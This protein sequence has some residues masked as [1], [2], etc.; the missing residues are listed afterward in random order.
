MSEKF[1]FKILFFIFFSDFCVCASIEP[2]RLLL[3]AESWEVQNKKVVFSDIWHRRFP[4]KT[5]KN[6]FFL[7][8]NWN[9]PQ[10]LP[11]GADGR[12][13]KRQYSNCRLKWSFITALQKNKNKKNS[14]TE[15]LLP[16]KESITLEYFGLMK[17]AE[18]QTLLIWID[19]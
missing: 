12:L 11:L 17:Y 4:K 14:K 7:S 2:R 15:I 5:K 19:R 3:E 13:S 9:K 1:E 16:Y 10:V 8:H 18:F 6:E